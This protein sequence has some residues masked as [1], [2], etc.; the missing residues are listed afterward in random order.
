MKVRDRV[1]GSQAKPRY[2]R[3]EYLLW[4][5]RCLSTEGRRTIKTQ[6][7]NKY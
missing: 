4:S 2:N 6:G 1:C 5:G 3:L 7:I